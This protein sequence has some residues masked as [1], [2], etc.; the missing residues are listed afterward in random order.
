MA[1][2]ILVKPLSG[3]GAPICR[4]PAKAAII[5]HFPAIRKSPGV[6]PPLAGDIIGLPEQD[7]GV[8]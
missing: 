6:D 3:V 4:A 2:I 8:F 1:V 5:G 7:P